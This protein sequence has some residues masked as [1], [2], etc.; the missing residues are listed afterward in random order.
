MTYLTYPGVVVCIEGSPPLLFPYDPKSKA[1]VQGAIK[2]AFATSDKAKGRGEKV[3]FLGRTSA[4]TGNG[5]SFL[6]LAGS[7]PA[8]AAEVA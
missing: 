7:S 1:S 4:H 3:C 2:A 6:P 5:L 8:F